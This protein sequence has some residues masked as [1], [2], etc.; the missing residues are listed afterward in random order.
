VSGDGEHIPST[1]GMYA[2]RW[3]PWMREIMDKVRGVR[4]GVVWSFK[5]AVLSDES[6]IGPYVESS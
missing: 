1:F 5:R 2:T 4:K 6:D 3:E